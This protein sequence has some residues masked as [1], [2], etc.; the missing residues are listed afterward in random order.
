MNRKIVLLCCMMLVTAFTIV[1]PI[2]NVEAAEKPNADFYYTPNSPA[3]TDV[4]QFYDLSTDSD[5]VIEGIL[6]LLIP[7]VFSKVGVTVESLELMSSCVFRTYSDVGKDIVV[8]GR[9]IASLTVVH[10]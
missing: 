9:G 8:A 6:V 4:I 2:K 3:K 5:G 1:F 10:R 7:R